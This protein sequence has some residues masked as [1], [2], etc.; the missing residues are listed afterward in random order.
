MNKRFTPFI[1]AILLLSMAAGSSYGQ[2]KK[3][4]KLVTVESTVTDAEGQPI[5]GAVISG[6]EGALE[7]LS[8]ANGEFTIQV[9]ENTDLL[10]EADGYDVR[11]I[12]IYPDSNTPEVQLDKALF[13][14]EESNLINI[15]FGKVMRKD[16]VGSLTVIDP[17][18]LAFYD[19]TQNI[20]DA[21]RGRVP[22][23]LGNSN[24]RGT[25]N[26]LI[27]VDGIPRDAS[28]INLAEVEQITVLKDANSAILYGVQAQNG[29][30]LV[31]T[32]HG[33][34]FKRKIDV[35]FEQGISE[36]IV[37]PKYLNSAQSMSL[38]NE[39]LANDG[40][41]AAF[42]DSVINLYAGG[43]NPYLY[44]DVNFYSGEFLNNRK[45][46]SRV[47]GEFSGGSEVAQY[48]ASV[49]WTH[50]ESLYKLIEG[51]N[52][53]ADRFNVR[54]SVDFK[55]NDFIKSNIGAVVIYDR[56]NNPH[57]NFWGDA[58]TV[59]PYLYPQLIPLSMV[60]QETLSSAVDLAKVERVNGDFI[61]G[62]T[63]QYKS[64][65]YGNMLFA[66]YNQNIQRTIQFNNSI[67]VDLRNV[68]E[69]LK[70]KTYLSFDVYNTFNQFVRNDYAVY[71]PV[72]A[73][74]ADGTD[75]IANLSQ[76]G[77]DLSTGVENLDGA[78]FLRRT[79]A[80]AMLDYG[81][82]FNEDHSLSASLL[83][84][85]DKVNIE[86]VTI[87]I[88]HSHLGLRVAYGFRNK[89]L[90][91]FSSAYVNGFKLAEGNRGGFSP[92]LGVAWVAKN[93][94]YTESG[95][96]NYLKVRLSGGIINTEFSGTNYRLYEN[97][98]SQGG[99]FSWFDG[100]RSNRE[101]L[102]NRSANP[103]LTFEKVKNLNLGLEGYFLNR[104]IY[105]DAN[106]FTTRNSGQVV[107]RTIYPGF[108]SNYLPYENFNETGYT[109]AELG[110]I[111]SKAL[112]DFS[113]D[114]GTN[115]LYVTS[116]EVKRDEVWQNEY[117]Y[118]EGRP[119]DALYA[120]EA[121]GLFA[122]DADIQNSPVQAFGEVRPGDIKYRD[123]NGDGIINQN[124]EVMI[125]NSQPRFS[126]GLHATLRYKNLS[127]FAIGNGTTGSDRYFGGQYFWVQGNDR[128]SEEVLG[129]WTPA[130]ASTATYPRLSSGNSPNNFRNSTYW[131]YDNNY[132]SLS[133][134]QLSYD[135]PKTITGRWAVKNVGFYVRAMNLAMIGKYADKAQ[136]RIG[137]EP[138][139]RSYALGARLTF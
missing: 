99:G 37:M 5:P 82:T 86:A 134:V 27:I 78:G 8:D 79:G 90:V 61:L 68:T 12:T 34:A 106:V 58:A 117:Q 118:R 54:A 75:Y 39:A 29:V 4:Q 40:R 131:L 114:L 93:L 77:T 15:P 3:E 18:E 95:P 46:F 108:I 64:N 107:Q 89:Y 74:N 136:L 73:K 11:R 130:T 119:A 111:W 84:Y 113:L 71:Q 20:V 132:F 103:D 110:L 125:G 38:Y 60:N 100:A 137:G 22:G 55:A 35:S 56:F 66:G 104:A 2:N 124:D 1:L 69:G 105:V 19:N 50:S 98:L 72:W 80:Y 10:I 129:R 6:K 81:R 139:Y 92:S 9:P 25:G 65:A 133:R 87:P 123:Q 128:Y 14:K 59:Q 28:N 36:P 21:I 116:K 49:G 135:L 31:T 127:L 52:G 17:K 112:G 7:V 32:K 102:I 70:F 121:L 23:L 115:F 42:T 83:G 45:P 16:V 101:T 26:A 109:G 126:Y 30:I 88:K 76:I 24:I 85:F 13:S 41:P 48:F 97:T 57:G 62:G 94:D 47:I 67:D 43:T 53:D 138:N 63:P 91:D 122:D 120:L 96:V 33:Q 51:N 44:P